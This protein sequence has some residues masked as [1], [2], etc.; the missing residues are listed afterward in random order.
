[1][2]DLQH[3]LSRTS[4]TVAISGS[5]R[6]NGGSRRR[7]SLPGNWIGQ[8]STFDGIPSSHECNSEIPLPALG[9]QNSRSSA[10]GFGRNPKKLE[11]ASLRVFSINGI[12]LS[13]FGKRKCV[14]RKALNNWGKVSSVPEVVDYVRSTATGSILAVSSRT[15]LLW[16]IVIAGVLGTAAATSVF[17]WPRLGGTPEAK[18]TPAP[19]APL[20]ISCIGRIQ[21]EDGPILIGARSLSGQPSLVAQLRVHEGDYVKAGQIVAILNS[22]DQLEAASRQAEA[23]IKL[24]EA[25][26][27]QV[28]AGAKSADIRRPLASGDRPS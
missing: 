24:A 27:D 4:A 7:S 1:M 26:R 12:V 20:G 17:V 5:I 23:R 14:L 10:A 19:T 2:E 15:R 13:G 25:Q 16:F 22:R 18:A 3:R 28:K 8:T 9:K 11:A 6:R 21:S